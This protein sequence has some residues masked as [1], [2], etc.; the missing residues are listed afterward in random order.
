MSD[1]IASLGL[2][3]DS[4]QVV[5]ATA[6][7]NALTAA[8][9][10]AAASATALQSAAATASTALASNA[11]AANG[12]S[13]SLRGQRQ[14]LRGLASD[15]ALLGPQFG[16]AATLASAL[17][18]GNEH[19]MGG[20]GSLKDAVGALL[21]P[22]NLVIGG[23]IALA[24]GS[25]IAYNAI[26]QTELQFGALSDRTGET[27]QQLHALDS[28][29]AFKGIDT[30]DFIKNMGQFSDLSAEASNHL[31]TM[32]ELFQANGVQAG[33]LTQNLLHA[34]DLIANA[35]T[36][37]DK[38]RLIQQLG[39]PATQQWVEYLSQGSVG[40]KAAADAAVQFGGDADEQLIKRAQEADE[41]WN[42][43]WKNFSTGAK[44]A[45]VSAAEG[46]AN[47]DSA[48]ANILQRGIGAIFGTG[49]PLTLAKSTI[50]AGHGTQLTAGDA[51]KFYGA[52]GADKGG[53]STP[54]V[55]PNVEKNNI[56]LIQQRIAALG[57][58]ASITQQVTQK[59][60]E[61]RLARLQPGS[62][63]TDADVT[64]IT[65]YTRAQALGTIAIQ[66]QTNTQLLQAQ[67]VGMGVGQAAAFTAVQERIN[68]AM[69]TGTPL[70]AAQVAELQKYA[71]ALGTATQNAALLKAQSDATFATSQIGRTDPDAAVATQLRQLY[72]DDY[73]SHLND[74]Y[75]GQLRLNS[76]LTDAK[77]TSQSVFSGMITD[78]GSATGRASLLT[79]ALT[80]ISQKLADIA[81]NNLSSALFGK[82]GAGLGGL[83]GIGGAQTTTPGQV[84]AV[85]DTGPMLVPQAHTGGLIGSDSLASRYIHPAYFD[86]AP[87]FHTGGTIGMDEVPIIAKKGE[88][89]L[90]P[91]QMASL[92]PASA[93][94]TT[95]HVSIPQVLTFNNT[96]PA[97]E[98]RM[99]AYVDASNKQAVSS[100]VQAV[101]R[102]HQNAPGTYLKN[103]K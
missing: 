86:N 59:E 82:A 66:Q 10:P 13:L 35:A 39:L 21:T 64:R 43:F 31:G 3:V 19:L 34:A 18:I 61:L 96:D 84:G 67:A 28:A 76:A 17:Y 27:V 30:T 69:L 49:N 37:A 6:A 36:N 42:T 85:G 92:S 22:T 62:Q 48:S 20:F 47:F 73:Q 32:A 75:A 50:A 65:E 68:A 74:A 79:N 33:T 14:V 102:A 29:A 2:A 16:T 54:T 38:Y 90:T 60:N 103:G 97:S 91:G 58:L 5:A 100:A 15:L 9:K 7:L 71:S 4:T 87:R 53:S 101:Q 41:K 11:A 81:A 24:A 45:F 46:L 72:G 83:F 98:A 51:S 26:K 63:I 70:T 93:T 25:Y 80:K 99:R 56:A 1:D 12:N 23:F 57:P 95:V 94:S 52:T 77:S 40:L 44:S 8:A 55:D 89:V 88:S 78:L